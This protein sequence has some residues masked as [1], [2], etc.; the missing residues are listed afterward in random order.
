MSNN[1]FIYRLEWDAEENK[2]AKWP[3]KWDDPDKR[4]DVKQPHNRMSLEQAQAVLQHLPCPPQPEA[5][6]L[7]RWLDGADG[8]FLLDLD[9]VI[10]K[11]TGVITERARSVLAMFPGAFVEYSS[12]GDGLHIIGRV[13]RSVLPPHRNKTPKEWDFDYE[14]YTIDR[15]IA[16][17]FNVMQAGDMAADCTAA[18]LQLVPAYFPPRTVGEGTDTRRADWRG[19]EDDDELIRRML[20]SRGS[21]AVALGGKISV[22]QLWEGD[23]EHNSEN[24]MA[25]ASHLAFWTG[26]DGDRIE[27]LMF[28]SGLV[29]KKWLKHRRYLR[30][31]TIAGACAS[32]TNVYKEPERDIAGVQAK[33]Y[34]ISVTLPSDVPALATTTPVLIAEDTM[35]TV[36]SLVEMVNGCNNMAEVHNRAIPAIQAASLPIAVIEPLVKAVNRRLELFD[37]KMSLPTLRQLLCPTRKRA[38]TTDVTAPEWVQRMCYI[39]ANDRFYDVQSGSIMTHKGFTAE[40]SRLM[41]MRENGRR[42]D[43]IQWAFERWNIAT[44]DAQMYHPL[45]GPYFTWGGKSYANNF[46][47]STLPEPVPITAQAAGAIERFMQHMYLFCGKRDDVFWMLIKWMAHNV[48]KPGVKIRW[49][50]LLKGVQGDGKSIMGVVMRAA[51]GDANVRITS[52]DTL[53]SSGGFTDW[54]AGY[55]V[56][57]IEEIFMDGQRRYELYEAMKNPIDLAVININPKGKT[58]FMVPNVTNHAASTNH[59]NGVPLD[60]SDRRWMVVFS[61]YN[62]ANEAALERGLT[63]AAD[64]P[65]YFKMIGNSCR[66]DPGQWRSWLISV[67]ISDFDPD[68]RSPHTPEKDRMIAASRD[69]GSDTF[70]DLLEEGAVGVHV[71][72]FSSSNL[73]NLLIIRARFDQADIPKTTAWGMILSRMGYER[74]PKK[75]KW[76]NG[77]HTLWA[78]PKI[79]SNLEKII[80]I[81]DSTLG[82]S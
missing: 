34:G 44:V 48:Q 76:N 61:A 41:P 70:T 40:Y 30:K 36:K 51:L 13:D 72:A 29:R 62:D 2:Y 42:E 65:D 69:S 33:V 26:C 68:A 12:S 64:L 43:P 17:T 15:G 81:L 10:D 6:A 23:C 60:P 82:K 22:Q 8:T 54:M 24:D 9:H 56:N 4:L 57:F 79:S 25:L 75:V 35:E 39:K 21:A 50:P 80:E 77:T 71:D 59:G 27:R 1:Y 31:L 5:F 38:E 55:A 46:L 11:T 45:E 37:A 49:A 16:L 20:A 78:R 7:G 58:D 73:R 18:L 63:S 14:F 67:D 74:Y 53:K 32:C 52:T 28:R 3:C 66:S 47:P 19:P